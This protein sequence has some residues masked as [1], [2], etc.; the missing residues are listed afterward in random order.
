MGCGGSKTDDKDSK[1]KDA[2]PKTT[3]RHKKRSSLTKST[4]AS[5]QRR[6]PKQKKPYVPKRRESE[7]NST[8]F[9]RSV[10][11]EGENL[12][13]TGN[14]ELET[15]VDVSTLKFINIRTLEIF[16]V[17]I[18]KFE[19]RGFTIEKCIQKT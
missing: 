7:Q 4:E 15:G 19:Q 10:P 13:L 5:P 16:A 1:E 14:W 18:L 11:V 9:Q 6:E 17:I 8:L 3:P 12:P 2:K